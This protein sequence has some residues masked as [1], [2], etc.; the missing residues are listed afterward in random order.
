MYHSDCAGIPRHVIEGGYSSPDVGNAKYASVNGV[1]HFRLGVDMV[2]TGS[3]R[4]CGSV[5]SGCG[6]GTSLHDSWDD[7]WRGKMKIDRG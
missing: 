7:L 4:A 5:G 3:R 6:P 1:E 2:D